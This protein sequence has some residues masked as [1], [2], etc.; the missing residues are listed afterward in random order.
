MLRS[1]PGPDQRFVQARRGLERL[2]TFAVGNEDGLGAPERRLEGVSME[3]PNG[4]AGD[5][6]TLS[7]AAGILDELAQTTNDTGAHV[8]P[9][10]ARG[11]WDIDLDAAAHGVNQYT[12]G[13]VGYSKRWLY[14][15]LQWSVS[16]QRRERLSHH[17]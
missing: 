1:A 10:R 9:I 4:R 5:D 12:N 17:W 16:A 14:G 11:G 8:D 6:E 7:G 3:F 15:P 2:R 13:L